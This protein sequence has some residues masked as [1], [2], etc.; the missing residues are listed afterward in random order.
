MHPELIKAHLRM[1]CITQADVA[2][3]CL[4]APTTVGAVIA[5]RS[6][7]EKIEKFLA[8]LLDIP[9]AELFPQWHGIDAGTSK[10]DAIAAALNAIRR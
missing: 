6:R 5:G 4:V 3:A 2:K 7:S 8:Q 1:K 9:L 10:S